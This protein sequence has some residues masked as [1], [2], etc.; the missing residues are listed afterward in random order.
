MGGSNTEKFSGSGASC[1]VCGCEAVN[2]YRAACVGE[3]ARA[4]MPLRGGR[5]ALPAVLLPLHPSL[6]PSAGPPGPVFRPH[7]LD[8]CYN[9]L[10]ALAFSHNFA[11]CCPLLKSWWGDKSTGLRQR[12]SRRLEDAFFGYQ[13]PAQGCMARVFVNFRLLIV[14]IWC[15]LLYIGNIDIIFRRKYGMT[16]IGMW[17]KAHCRSAG[18]EVI[19]D[20]WS[21][22]GS[23]GD[24]DACFLE[25][26]WN[27]LRPGFFSRLRCFLISS[28]CL[29]SCHQYLYCW[30]EQQLRKIVVAGI[31]WV[32]AYA[33]LIRPDE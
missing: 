16:C 27:A 31:V 29:T 30:V 18:E 10:H 13:V 11:P 12:V 14:C 9:R 24:E 25:V 33:L 28:D 8:A 22:E 4:R 5:G 17:S 15:V 32:D 1:E 19:Q 3:C 26:W 6:L 23:H 21:A 7:A 2:L 20:I